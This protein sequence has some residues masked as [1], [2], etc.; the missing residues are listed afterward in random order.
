MNNYRVR[1]QVVIWYEVAVQARSR[2]DAIAHAE[3][4]P[5]AHIQSTG[6]PVETET[7]LADP[8]SVNLIETR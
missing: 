5:P 3:G 2:N 8:E 4:L 6:E 7:G 1:V